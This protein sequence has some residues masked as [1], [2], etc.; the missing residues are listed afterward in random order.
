MFIIIIIITVIYTHC[1]I[2]IGILYTYDQ[3]ETLSST[4]GP[5]VGVIHGSSL[6]LT[7]YNNVAASKNN[8][9]Y[10]IPPLK[11]SGSDLMLNEGISKS[12]LLIV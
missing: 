6:L 5:V 3:A 1:K 12:S 10:D 7:N 9:N 4:L 2:I 8:N 11:G